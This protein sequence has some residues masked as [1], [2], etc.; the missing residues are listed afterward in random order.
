[1]DKATSDALL[2][3]KLAELPLGLSTTH[4]ESAETGERGIAW[5]DD[6]SCC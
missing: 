5:I 4:T 6:D 3:A 1:M 2:S